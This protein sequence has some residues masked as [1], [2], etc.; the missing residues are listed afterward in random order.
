MT[1]MVPT[2]TA[3]T[4]A[5]VVLTANVDGYTGPVQVA[6]QHTSK[7]SSLVN[8]LS[9]HLDGLSGRAGRKLLNISG[10]EVAY[11]GAATT[12]AATFQKQM[13]TLAAGSTVTGESF[14]GIKSGVESTFAKFP[15]ARS[16][17]IALTQDI[18]ELGV[19]GTQQITSLTQT[20]IKLGASTGEPMD[21]LA[22]GL[23][24]L[25]R[26]MGNENAAVIGR[27]ANALLVTSKNAGVSATGVLNFAQAIGPMARQAG[28]GEAGVI[29]ISTAFS[30][31][32]ADGYVAANTFNSVIGDMTTLMATGSPELAKYSNLVGMN[33]EQFTKFAK[34]DAAGAFTKVIQAIA[35]QGPRGIDTLNRLGFEGVR[36]Q[37]AITALAQSGDLQKQITIATSAT[38]GTGALDK[39][40]STAFNNLADSAARVRNTMTQMATG[41]GTSLTGPLNGL[42][43]GV[44]AVVGG[45][46]HLFG[47]LTPIRG[48]FTIGAAALT[49]FAGVALITAAAVGKLALA[50]FALRSRPAQAFRTG[51]RMGGREGPA[52]EMAPWATP[53]YRLGQRVGAAPR[54][55]RE[56]FGVPGP[57]GPGGGPPAPWWQRMGGQAMRLPI[58]LARTQT[59]FLQEA[60]KPGEQRVA[61]VMGPAMQR[62]YRLRQQVTGIEAPEVMPGQI[63]TERAGLFSRMAGFLGG[64]RRGFGGQADVQPLQKAANAAKDLADRLK[65]AAEATA[66]GTGAREK[67]DA[68]YVA[69]QEKAQAAAQALAA[70]EEKAAVAAAGGAKGQLLFTRQ[71]GALFGALTKMYATSLGA[72][73]KMTAQVG[74]TALKPLAGALLNPYTLGLVA[75]PMIYSFIRERGFRGDQSRNNVQA[76]QAYNDALG[77]TT[78]Q[79]SKLGD[80]SQ[81]ASSTLLNGIGPGSTFAQAAQFGS[82]DALV[83]AGQKNT[84]KILASLAATPGG[85]TNAPALAQLLQAY[86]I[87]D[88]RALQLVQIN[89]AAAGFTGPTIQTASQAYNAQ[90]GRAPTN[91]GDQYQALT[92]QIMGTEGIAKGWSSFMG[93]T[94]SAS[95]QGENLSHQIVTNMNLEYDSNTKLY[96]QRF[97]EQKKLIEQVQFL[98]DATGNLDKTGKHT[99]LQIRAMSESMADM[100]TGK[101]ADY[102]KALQKQFEPAGAGGYPGATKAQ[103][104]QI[105]AIAQAQGISLDEAATQVKGVTPKPG[106]VVP[107]MTPAQQSK[108]I[109]AALQ[110]TPEGKQ[111]IKDLEDQFGV[112]TLDP[113][114]FAKQLTDFYKFGAG[115]GGALGGLGD[116]G[117]FAKNNKAF[118]DSLTSADPTTLARGMD[119][120]TAKTT[121]LGGGLAGA[122]SG[123]EELKAAAGS[124]SS[125]LYQQ[126]DAAQQR[127][128]GQIQYQQPQLGR[129]AQ[130]APLMQLYQGA[131]AGLYQHARTPQAAEDAQKQYDTAKGALLDYAEQ[132]RQTELSMLQTSKQFGMQMTRAEEDFSIQRGQAQRDYR[133]QVGRSERDFG[134]QM[135]HMNRDYH[136]QVSRA[137]RD[138]HTQTLRAER[139]FRIQMERETQQAAE[140]IY[141]PFQRIQAQFTENAGTVLLLMKEQNQAI[142]G[143]Y[144]NLGSLRKLGLTQRAIDTM[145]LAD[146][147]NAQQTQTLVESLAQDP[148][149]VAQI[150]AQV[151]QRVAATGKLVH[152]SFNEQFRNTTADFRKQMS[153][154]A[155]DFRKSMSDAAVDVNNARSDAVT[156]QHNA[157]SDMATDYA[158]T[159]HDANVQY[160]NALKRAGE[161]LKF[162]LTDWSGT[163]SDL[164]SGLLS[165]ALGSVKKWAPDAYNVIVTY[166]DQLKAKYPQLFDPTAMAG[167]AV[168]RGFSAGPSKIAPQGAAFF[169]TARGNVGY[170][171]DGK[172]HM[173][174]GQTLANFMHYVGTADLPINKVPGYQTGGISTHRQLAYVSETNQPEIHL[175]A[176]GEQTVGFLAGLVSEV[177]RH[178][179]MAMHTGGHGVAGQAVTNHVQIDKSTQFNGDITVQAS[180]PDKM[181]RELAEK[182]RVRKLSHPSYR[183]G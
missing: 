80:A 28:I 24:Q 10:Q 89:A 51:F 27:Y 115:E 175:P 56:F 76:I 176:A 70:A 82:S 100:F 132:Q 162:A 19:T 154:T 156:A 69:A 26:L 47:S 6:A 102:R 109:F 91:I 48:V 123:L 33:T 32:G 137:D 38:G 164:N 66:A 146:P 103:A 134:I 21:Q 171:Q 140:T 73:L 173:L 63:P 181:A 127:I 136:L 172:A 14:K 11:L 39:A 9:K 122:V 81:S 34:A 157:L 1:T 22:S 107:T 55:F 58:W 153:D 129:V 41:I 182:A 67:A 177:S 96:G 170:W 8:D 165:A 142:E 120:L 16:D 166:L 174:S 113:S 44:N 71:S 147:K 128:M 148:Q 97:A 83:A 31:A 139:D 5:P 65:Q 130:G 30:K 75:A 7:L 145:Q 78:A 43:K 178:M 117:D 18:S 152:S 94:T 87:T 12:A 20:F 88:P 179:L 125:A 141:N 144:T 77:I 37:A 3:T 17:V 15:T 121:Q 25:S 159:M 124:S 126:A 180:D 29:G 40:S 2:T 92:K 95:K 163:L 167:G 64:F 23:I 99:D 42:L 155:A 61:P 74:A 59:E 35:Q 150:N 169:K 143:Q 86:N 72:G 114:K 79:V 106:V 54:Q 4:L 53:F 119:V 168:P 149:L 45:F 49:A 57:T 116:L 101:A 111:H 161:D 90:R 36:T 68:A 98:D 62:L 50:S 13:S 118:N 84:D 133:N 158:N 105:H 60:T 160:Q 93:I 110:A 183:H 112:K 46:N 135:E 85:K 151:S 138:Y 52:E 108:A 104:A 131:Q